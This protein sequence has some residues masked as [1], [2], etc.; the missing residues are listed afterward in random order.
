MVP[1]KTQEAF[2]LHNQAVSWSTA[3]IHFSP[4]MP[5]EQRKR[6]KKHK[7]TDHDAQQRALEPDVAE[8]PVEDVVEELSEPGPSWIKPKKQQDRDPD[9][10]F[11]Y[12]DSDVKAYFRTVDL[13][14]RD[15]QEVTKERVEASEHDVDPNEGVFIST[16]FPLPQSLT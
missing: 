1:V 13:Q 12:V 7:K 6:G 14:I 5:R 3:T 10:P 16:H 2:K 11:G 9:A 15:W 8:V 4:Y